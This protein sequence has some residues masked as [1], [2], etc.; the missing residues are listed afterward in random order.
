MVLGSGALAFVLSST[1]VICLAFY[2]CPFLDYGYACTKIHPTLCRPLN[3]NNIIIDIFS[4]SHSHLGI[5]STQVDKAICINTFLR[6]SPLRLRHKPHQ[7]H[8][9]TFAIADDTAHTPR[10]RVSLINN[11]QKQS[12][13]GPPSRR[14]INHESPPKI[15]FITGP[16]LVV[17]ITLIPAPPRPSPP[18]PAASGASHV[19]S[20]KESH[21]LINHSRPKDANH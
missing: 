11:S 12:S 10:S 13:L 2:G 16:A 1:F 9:K 6:S 14:H 21:I 7:R 19:H 20:R 3:S 5:P 18:T 4:P 17:A 8:Q 15:M